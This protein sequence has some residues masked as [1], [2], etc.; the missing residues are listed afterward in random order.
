MD[1][2]LI[3]AVLI[4]LACILWLAYLV[5]AW[6]HRYDELADLLVDERREAQAT[7]DE[8]QTAEDL[9][10]AQRKRAE[11]LVREL[12]ATEVQVRAAIA[13]QEDSP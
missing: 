1:G 5:R 12:R 7:R 11:Y 3:A 4:E 13:T 9:L 2:L 6:H 8:L 10:D